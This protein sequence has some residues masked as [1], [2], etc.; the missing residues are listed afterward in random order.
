MDTFGKQYNMTTLLAPPI[1]CF[2]P[3][4]RVLKCSS[5]VPNLFG[6][7]KVQCL[8]K[9]HNPILQN[10]KREKE[11][12]PK[13]CFEYY[14]CTTM[15]TRL[16][17]QYNRITHVFVELYRKIQ[18]IAHKNNFEDVAFFIFSSS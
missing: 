11:M 9:S 6:Q 3:K 5:G 16:W 8:F 14:P 2:H 17:R 15:H 18:I 4:Y 1:V 7:N 13:G 12:P 10:F